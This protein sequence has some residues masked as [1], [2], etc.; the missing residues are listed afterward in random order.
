MQADATKRDTQEAWAVPG[1]QHFMNAEGESIR[2]GR[3]MREEGD[4]PLGHN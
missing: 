4:G 3:H 1:K 2:G